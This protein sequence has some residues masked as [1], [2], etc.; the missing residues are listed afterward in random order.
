VLVAGA[1]CARPPGPP[2]T[3]VAAGEPRVLPEH[4]A[5]S[6][7]ALGMPG[8]HR[9]FQVGHGS[10]VGN[11]DDALEWR[12]ASAAG[13]V[14]V[15][16][17]FFESDGVPVAHWWMVSGRESVHFEAA[18]VPRQALGDTS[19]MLSVLATATW[20]AEAPG[21]CALEVRV[22]ARAD[23][24][25]AIPWDA[26]D[27]DSY[28]E[29]WRD[30]F[31]V[32]NGRI[33]AGIDPTVTIAP[34]APRPAR[35]ALTRGPGPGALVA[36]ARAH[37][38]PGERRSWHFWMPAY[39][40]DAP[41]PG[42][43]RIAGHARVV[44]EARDTWRHWLAQGSPLTTSDSLVDAAWR[45][46]L[47]TLLVS[48]EREG[49]AWV[50]LGNP[51]QY[52]DVWLRDAARTVRALAVAGY[53]E[54]ARSDALTITRFR[55]PSGV[56]LSQ[57][58]QLDGTGQ[59]LWAFAQAATLPPAP[60][61]AS[62]T[63]PTVRRALTWF[64]FQCLLTRQLGLR[65]A[66]LL[67]YADPRDNELT[68]AQ[69][70]GNDA[71]GIAGC[72]A[73]ATLAR[74]AGDD[75]LA[76]AADS[77]TAAYCDAFRAALAHTGSRDVPPS[78]QG[79]GR[80]WG[81]LAVGYPTRVLPADDPRLALLAR[82]VRARAGRT[83]LVSYGPLDTLHTYLGA[84]LAEWALLAGNAAEARAYLADLLAHSS[85]T[86]GQAEL[87]A[88][89]GG[90]FGSNLPP[91][92]TAAAALVD[93]VRNMIVCDSRDTL[94][95]ALG[96]DAG[97]WRGARFE[98]AATRFGV[99]DVALDSPAPDRRRARWNPVAVP[100]RVRVPDGEQA[101]QV[102]TPGARLRGGRWVECPPRAK[103]VE[104][105]VVGAR[106]GPP[107]AEGAEE[108]PSERGRSR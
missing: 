75:A 106:V 56:L 59:S 14:R 64:E 41:G 100:T 91:H 3:T 72:R 62:R 55:L 42:L 52:R 13:P 44:S 77:T 35:P 32:R 83:G 85:S 98:R 58:G 4:Y 2:A 107:V 78:W 16:P 63:L 104:F 25:A 26:D 8:A 96:G 45:A 27:T 18:A 12:L 34:E 1:G 97:W 89:A 7:A 22:R 47:V 95:L 36:T 29:C 23:D 86:L 49:V 70:V 82:R 6:I 90:S 88:R 33:V 40:S 50:P 46:A 30:R 81:N 101:I 54:M 21:E 38:A 20:L 53:A 108:R 79:V 69:L 92:A 24:P 5:R 37:L 15:S 66:G 10:V 105:R 80:D 74:L 76:R 93:L 48:Q 67:P 28:E 99:I 102:I 31:A 84:D 9:A 94:E 68:R 19:L 57:W 43:E 11:G 60:E 71:W 39:P 87:F 73:A 65:F 61:W 103:E 17:V 51:F